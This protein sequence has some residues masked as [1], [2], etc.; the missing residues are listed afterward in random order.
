MPQNYIWPHELSKLESFTSLIWTNHD[1]GMFD[2]NNFWGAGSWGLLILT[3]KYSAF[4]SF[5]VFFWVLNKTV[6]MKQTVMGHLKPLMISGWLTCIP[7]FPGQNEDWS[8]WGSSAVDQAPGSARCIAGSPGIWSGIQ[9]RSHNQPWRLWFSH[10]R[11]FLKN[12]VAYLS[13]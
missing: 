4:H 8:W 13:F 6:L 2:A 7:D 1:F 12:R 5:L 11:V 3:A 9:E 10:H